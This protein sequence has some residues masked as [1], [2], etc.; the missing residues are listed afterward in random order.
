MTSSFYMTADEFAAHDLAQSGADWRLAAYHYAEALCSATVPYAS[1]RARLAGIAIHDL[2]ESGASEI[3]VRDACRAAGW[4]R[5]NPGFKW[6]QEN[7]AA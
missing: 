5:E 3:A 2:L 7:Q 6:L 4:L 1:R